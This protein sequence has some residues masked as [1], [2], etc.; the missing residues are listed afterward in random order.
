MPELANASATLSLA[1]DQDFASTNISALRESIVAA[2]LAE[3]LSEE[4][5]AFVHLFPGSVRILIGLG[6][7][8]AA[9]ALTGSVAAGSLQVNGISLTADTEVVAPYVTAA[10]A[11]VGFRD[12]RFA[13]EATIEGLDA[14]T[15]GSE[16]VVESRVG[17]LVQAT[18]L[19][20]PRLPAISFTAV[21]APGPELFFDAPSVSVVVKFL[22]ERESSHVAEGTEADVTLVPSLALQGSV[23]AQAVTRSC[24]T[25][26]SVHEGTMCSVSFDVPLEWFPTAGDATVDVQVQLAST[27]RVVSTVTLKE[28][29]AIALPLA[30]ESAAGVLCRFPAGRVMSGSEFDVECFAKAAD[31]VPVNFFQI[32]LAPRTSAI[33]F[34]GVEAASDRW[35]VTTNQY[36]SRIVASGIRIDG[37]DASVQETELVHLFTAKAQ[38]VTTTF[39][40]TVAVNARV[41]EL[42]SLVGRAVAPYSSAYVTDSVTSPAQRS[43]SVVVSPL[44]TA[45]V[46]AWAAAPTLINTAPLM[47]DGRTGGSTGLSVVRVTADG[48]VRASVDH[49]CAG[50]GVMSPF[51]CTQVAFTASDE[52]DGRV[53][54]SVISGTFV[55][56]V[57]VRVM[58]V[59]SLVLH[60]SS[61]TLK[62]VTTASLGLGCAEVFQ[63]AH[64]GIEA[65]LTSGTRSVSVDVT[66]LAANILEVSSANAAAALL[67]LPSSLSEATA[68]TSHLTLTAGQVLLQGQQKGEAQ[69]RAL[70]TSEDGSRTERD[71]VALAVGTSAAV[72]THVQSALVASLAVGAEEPAATGVGAL[73]S[74]VSTQVRSFFTAR[75]QVGV[76][77][78]VIIDGDGSQTLVLENNSG[79]GTSNAAMLASTVSNG[80]MVS[81]SAASLIAIRNTGLSG[82]D[83]VHVAVSAALCDAQDA[84][85]GKANFLDRYTA[86]LA[87]NV[88]VSTQVIAP[89][90]SAAVLAGVA[91]EVRVRV[92]A[93]FEDGTQQDVT[94]DPRTTIDVD[95]FGFGALVLSSSGTAATVSATRVVQTG[96]IVVSFG[97]LN[98][99]VPISMV[100]AAQ[101]SMSVHPYPEFPGSD[102]VSVSTLRRIANTD[103][104]Q[105][106]RLSVKLALTNGQMVDVTLNA[107]TQVVV[108]PPSVGLDAQTGILTTTETGAAAGGDATVTVTFAGGA[109]AA[110]PVTISVATT[111]AAP[112][113][114]VE[115]T[116]TA[117]SAVFGVVNSEVSAALAVTASLADGTRLPHDYLFSSAG[118]GGVS[119]RFPGLIQFASSSP[120][121]LGVDADT[122]R[123]TLG[124]NTNMGAVL[125]EAAV[126][127]PAAGFESATAPK[128]AV[129]VNLEPAPLDFDLGALAPAAVPVSAKERGEA[130]ELPLFLRV[131]EDGVLP[132]ALQLDFSF[133]AASLAVLGVAKDS[134]WGASK[135]FTF[136]DN[137]AGTLRIIG[138][139]LVLEA[140]AS[141]GDGDLVRLATITFEVQSGAAI[142]YA[143]IRGSIVA[144]ADDS[145]Q[146]LVTPGTPIV[147]GAIGVEVTDASTEP[148]S[149]A[150]RRRRGVADNANFPVAAFV[151]SGAADATGHEEERGRRSVASGAAVRVYG[152]ANGDGE[153]STLD[154][155]FALDYASTKLTDS[156]S[157]PAVTEA[158][159][160][161]LDAD[162][163][164]EIDGSDAEYLLGVLLGQRVFVDVV[165]ASSVVLSSDCKFVVEV[166]A[167]NEK[168]VGT[169]SNV[170][171]FVDLESSDRNIRSHLQS[172]AFAY[173][174]LLDAKPAPFN[175]TLVQ[176]EVTSSGT[177][178]VEFESTIP[179]ATDVGISLVVAVDG[180]VSGLLG[181]VKSAPYMFEAEV[182]TLSLPAPL[183]S[184]GGVTVGSYN[185]MLVR[186]ITQTTDECVP[187]PCRELPCLNGGTCTADGR[188]F[189]CACAAGYE[190]D[191][192]ETEIDECA[193]N[194]AC[195]NGATCVDLLGTYACVCAPGFTGDSCEQNID[196]CAGA[197]CLNGGTCTDGI[198]GFSCA[199]AAGFEGER[200]ETNTNECLAQPCRNGA[201]CVDGVD[202]FE[203]VCLPGFE[204]QLCE[205]NIDECADSP[206]AFGVC[207]DGI[208]SFTCQCQ[209]GYAG[210]LCDEDID[211]CAA[212]PC[213][214][215]ATC[216]DHI[217]SYTCQCPQG[218]S[219][220]NCEI[221]A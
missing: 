4:D 14:L 108:S 170:H 131:G 180:H 15:P 87:L 67:D 146:Q 80:D 172:S 78:S 94:L 196:D 95:T 213:E 35:A 48:Q 31:G 42:L 217:N 49:T 112:V 208:A 167:V 86:V 137:S 189:T 117:P 161:E 169:S 74:T 34:V 162:G 198:N 219:G 33:R 209:P 81:E 113:D 63:Q 68:P 129:H 143:Q 157:L 140:D 13:E 155:L 153:F 84:V 147:A 116:V 158:Q 5:L 57:A 98:E 111:G 127:Q 173:G 123:L 89:A 150:R 103:T 185:P 190:G 164:G 75:A 206:C 194:S 61:Q 216:I 149:D 70:I 199:C 85:L 26:A 119:A 107:A 69:L 16:V 55:D 195:K 152:D 212:N 207:V 184:S 11:F 76:V 104:F 165:A 54:V 23:G 221:G 43:A 132:Q 12:D 73:S 186:S 72:A 110:T 28:Q 187:D 120:S 90:T 192:C 202:S 174:V 151:A 21:V 191:N 77:V 62:Y 102:Q 58:R 141:L 82:S 7:T 183:E 100:D 46:L 92:T 51:A 64:V 65:V 201:Q 17:S 121:T 9:K 93:T 8:D 66:H 181:G 188:D 29:P 175:G 118:D 36:V 115:L 144:L 179:G 166:A 154:F 122:G 25:S 171:V 1:I 50:V 39:A 52:T 205:A 215:G 177:F 10:G 56:T 44:P 178:R 96:A 83:F 101:L 71:S 88:N 114:V 59:S 47:P 37:V 6:S 19:T 148:S 22:D 133:D 197:P 99:T 136:V 97:G 109:L 91:G 139:G 41:L 124:G 40:F 79:T 130:F 138:F 204:G 32:Q 20:T 160:L 2:L 3:G 159:L 125:I 220:D 135:P 134:G 53:E 214:N 142:D 176:A 126:A 45:G 105:Q 203:C 168:G 27:A 211:E 30:Q 18:T 38:V 218:Y 145:N 106:A 24:T 182:S 210:V 193:G 60:T 156:S 128:V 200:C 163:N